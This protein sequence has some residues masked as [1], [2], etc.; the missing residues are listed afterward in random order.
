M[1]PLMERVTYLRESMEAQRHKAPKY[2]AGLTGR[3][4]QVLRLIS[5]GKTNLEIAQELILSERTVQG[6]I[7]TIYA[8]IGAR[9]RADATAFAMTH[10]VLDK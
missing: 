1:R 7:A 3:Q 4:V 8:K 5:Q 2:P 6:H 10:L 9:N